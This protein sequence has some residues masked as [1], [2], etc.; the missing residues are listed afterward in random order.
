VASAREGEAE[1]K[2]VHGQARAW[3]RRLGPGTGLA[4][5]SAAGSDEAR[6]RAADGAA[7]IVWGKESVG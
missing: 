2:A 4:R 7:A 5:R 3:G 6:A 1:R